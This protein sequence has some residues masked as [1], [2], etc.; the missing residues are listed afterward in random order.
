MNTKLYK[1]PSY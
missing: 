1:Y